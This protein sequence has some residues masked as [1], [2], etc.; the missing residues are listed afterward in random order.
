MVAKPASFVS[1]IF[2]VVWVA[3]WSAVVLVVILDG[4]VELLCT[5]HCNCDAFVQN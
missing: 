5:R 3:L 2:G 1:L 4:C